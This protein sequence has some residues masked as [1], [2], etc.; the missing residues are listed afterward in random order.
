MLAPTKVWGIDDLAAV[1][2]PREQRRYNI[3]LLADHNHWNTNVTDDVFQFEKYSR[4]RVTI[5]NPIRAKMRR[6]DKWLD[7]LRGANFASYDV[8]MIHFSLY[9]LNPYFIPE[10]VQA[11]IAEYRGVKMQTIRDEYRFIDEMTQKQADL[12]IDVLFSVL[13]PEHIERVYHHSHVRGMFKVSTLPGLASEGLMRINV[14]PI[15]N[16]GTHLSYRSR[17][18]PAEL[19]SFAQQKIELGL[20][21][22]E[23]MPRF[24]L[25]CDISTEEKDRKYGSEW[26]RLHTSSKA[27]LSAPGGVSIFDFSGEA[28]QRAGAYRQDHPGAEERD[29]IKEALADLDGNIVHKQITPRTFEAIALKT[30]LVMP[31]SDYRDVLVPWRHYIPIADDFSNIDE[32]ADR[33]RDDEFLQELVDRTYK[34]ILVEGGYT[35]R[36]FV[37]KFDAAIDRLVPAVQAGRRE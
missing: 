9:L 21:M 6:W 7:R 37:R 8:L 16:R 23:L 26:V 12:G 11:A 17:R 30:A 35:R 5:R 3:L 1:N 33:L 15:S 36:E 29:I 32:V 14:P 4:H 24:S 25:K 10:D 19:G 27:V 31:V 20:R 28:S 22:A 2:A 18:L 34:E 13:R